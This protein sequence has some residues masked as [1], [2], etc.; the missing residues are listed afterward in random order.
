VITDPGYNLEGWQNVGPGQW[1]AYVSVTFTGGVA[2]YTFALEHSTPQSE[3]YL[4]MYSAKEC[5]GEPVRVDVWSADGQHAYRD[6]WV[7]IPWCP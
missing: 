5:G 4:T 1:E 6:I 3:N 2:P 7:V